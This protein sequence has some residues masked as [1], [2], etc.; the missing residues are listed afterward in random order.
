ME[1]VHHDHVS[2]KLCELCNER[3][4]LFCPSDSAFLCFRCDA[5]VHQANILVARHLRLTLCSQ[6]HSLTKNRFFPC[7]PRPALCPSCSLNISDDSDLRSVSSSSSSTCISSTQSISSTTQRK[8]FADEVNSAACGTGRFR[9]VKL[10]DPRAATDLFMHWC[11]K[12]GMHSEEAKGTVQT[13]CDAL[14]ICFSQFRA[15]P[16]RVG[17]AASLWFGLRSSNND[18][19]KSTWRFLKR[20]EEISGVPAK[21]ILATEIKLR[22]IVKTNNQRRQGMEE[23]WGECSP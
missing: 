8:R 10:P 7:S 13:A 12:L 11:A 1:E 4:L 20:F 9:S 2:F 6:C 5:K 14:G 22:K 15:L 18:G 17:L 19:S 21:I 23:S 3:A 16:V